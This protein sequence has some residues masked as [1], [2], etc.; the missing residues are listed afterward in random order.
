MIRNHVGKLHGC[1][2]GHDYVDK[3]AHEAAGDG[4]DRLASIYVKHREGFLEEVEAIEGVLEQKWAR[5]ALSSR[6]LFL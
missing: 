3:Q 1:V 5:I 4:G 6:P 2:Q